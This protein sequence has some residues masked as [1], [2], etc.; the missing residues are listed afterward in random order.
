MAI[1]VPYIGQF[2]HG[3]TT[4]AGA[5]SER[6]EPWGHDSSTTFPGAAGKLTPREFG[7]AY[8]KA[9]LRQHHAGSRAPSCCNL[10]RDPLR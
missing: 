5:A 3:P 1:T 4:V 10:E 8:H 2:M 6:T 7:L 9:L